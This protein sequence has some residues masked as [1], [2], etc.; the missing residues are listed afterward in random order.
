M[1][2]EDILKNEKLEKI[3]SPHPLSFMKYQSLCIFLIIW[4]VLVLWLI[5]F[6]EWSGLFGSEWIIFFVWAV[7]LLLVGIFASLVTIR[8]SIL[9]FYML[10]IVIG[11]ALVLWLGL[12][13]E[14]GFFCLLYTSPSPRDRTRS[15]M[16]SSA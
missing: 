11:I 3:L 15:R 16:P 13:K 5:N 8:W 14:V 2:R 6:S 10:V 1:N 9:F 12:Q 7:V 4:G